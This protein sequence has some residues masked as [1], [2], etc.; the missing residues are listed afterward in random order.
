MTMLQNGAH[1]SGFSPQV[2][3]LTASTCETP[4]SQLQV[5]IFPFLKRGVPE[6]VRVFSFLT[7]IQFPWK[8]VNGSCHTWG[9]T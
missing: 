6:A 7:G 3:G 1:L 2:K 4:K 8:V 9:R 5:M